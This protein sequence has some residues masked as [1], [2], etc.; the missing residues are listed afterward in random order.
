[1]AAKP[2]CAHVES[3]VRETLGRIADKWTLVIVDE[4]DTETLRFSLLQRRVGGIS[5]K[6]LTQTLREMEKDGLVERIVYAEV[7]PRVEYLLTPMGRDLG[8]AVCNIWR[9]AKKHQA[10]VEQARQN[11]EARNKLRRTAA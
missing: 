5:Q 2:E 1:M 10:R 11:F 7:P 8:E 9:W 6:M 4:L 3:L